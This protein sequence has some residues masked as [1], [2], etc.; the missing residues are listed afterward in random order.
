MKKIGKYTNVSFGELHNPK[1]KNWAR[2]T[3]NCNCNIPIYQADTDIILGRVDIKYIVKSK[4]TLYVL[5][6]GQNRTRWW[7]H[8]KPNN[9]KVTHLEEPFEDIKY[10]IHFG[11]IERG[12]SLTPT[13]LYIEMDDVEK[14]NTMIL[15]QE[16]R[17]KLNKLNK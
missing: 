8:S 12:G 17:K 14:Y 10:T 5:H 6:G 11:Y 3:F 1:P 13:P 4:E 9:W 2:K 7:M 15:K 16:R